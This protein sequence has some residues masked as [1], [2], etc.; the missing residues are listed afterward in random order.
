MRNLT[1]LGWECRWDPM[2]LR[3]SWHPVGKSG[4]DRRTRVQRSQHDNRGDRGASKLGRDI[5]SDTGEAQHMYVQHLSSYTRCLEV[6]GP[7]TA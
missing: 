5:R 3:L 4:L 7:W 6:F 2:P 1:R